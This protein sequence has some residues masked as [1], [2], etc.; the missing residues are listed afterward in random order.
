MPRGRRGCQAAG[1]EKVA[2]GRGEWATSSSWVWASHWPTTTSVAAARRLIADPPEG[3][4]VRPRHHDLHR[5]S[6]PA[7]PAVGREGLPVTSGVSLHAP[8]TS[9]RDELVPINNRW[10]MDE[11]AGCCRGSMPTDPPAG[12]HRIR[13]HPRH[14]RSTVASRP[15]GV[16][17]AEDTLVHVNLIPLNPT[18]GSKWTA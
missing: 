11:G 3:L 8:T 10:P 12:V 16:T 14:Q 9:L 18:P 7:H 2:G 5:R 15:P 17:A 13:A 1:P 6:G 4:T